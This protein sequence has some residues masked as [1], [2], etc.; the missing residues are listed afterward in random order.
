MRARVVARSCGDRQRLGILPFDGKAVRS[1]LLLS[2][3]F[4]KVKSDAGT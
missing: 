3:P 4:G 2:F 1:Q